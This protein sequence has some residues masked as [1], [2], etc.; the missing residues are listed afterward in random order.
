MI[1]LGKWQTLPVLSVEKIGVYLGTYDNKVLLPRKQVP[2]DVRIGD[3]IEVFIYKD[4]SDRLIA[5][6]NTPKVAV[7]EIAPLR[8]KQITKIGAFLDWGLEKDLFLPFS[9]Q[10]GELEEGMFY[11][12]A[13]YVD[14]SDR[15]AATM[16]ID[17]YIKG[18]DADDKKKKKSMIRLMTDAENVYRRIERRGGYLDYDDKADPEIIEKDFGL[19]KNAFKRAVGVLYK[20]RRLVI[21]E[22]SIELI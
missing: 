20:A 18:S 11:P 15:L 22:G 9:Q 3:E 4:S 13:L 16:W 6:V 1:M 8:V 12:V 5:T 17:K 2:Q 19:S 14:K 10:T 21:N 7:G